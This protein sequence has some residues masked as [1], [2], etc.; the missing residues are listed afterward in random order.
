VLRMSGGRQPLRLLF[1]AAGG[2]NPL[3]LLL[4]ANVIISVC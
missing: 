4:L 2:Q 3:L 1:A